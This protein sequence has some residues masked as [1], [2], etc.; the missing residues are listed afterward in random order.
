M[1]VVWP[2]SFLWQ[3]AATCVFLLLF[4]WSLP[5]PSHSR[6]PLFSHQLSL[7]HSAKLTFSL[8][9]PA[10]FFSLRYRVVLL[11]CSYARTDIY[12]GWVSHFLLVFL[13]K[14]KK[15]RLLKSKEHCR[16]GYRARKK[17][18]CG[19]Y[20]RQRGISR[21]TSWRKGALFFFCLWSFQKR[22]FFIHPYLGAH[23]L[24][25]STLLPSSPSSPKN[26]LLGNRRKSSYLFLS[27]RDL[28]RITPPSGRGRI[29]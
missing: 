25:P 1:F 3:M 24:C 29:E 7:L 16:I 14:R 4:S 8:F 5:P 9:T 12:F 20:R 2:R 15:K 10:L 27:F 17:K 6:A 13:G 11:S 19:V 21:K 23:S 22:N 18:I 26:P 28:T